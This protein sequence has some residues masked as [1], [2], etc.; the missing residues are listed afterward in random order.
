MQERGRGLTREADITT[1][2]EER[3][4]SGGEQVQRREAPLPGSLFGV[5]HQRGTQTLPLPG[6]RNRQRAEQGNCPVDFQPHHADQVRAIVAP[7]EVSERRGGEIG[8]GQAGGGQQGADGGWI[9]ADVD[10]RECN[11]HRAGP[12]QCRRGPAVAG[13][14]S[15][16]SI[17]AAT[18]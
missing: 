12:V 7:P 13:A 3:L 14:F 16:L 15:M 11:S 9:G 8:S 18:A 4:G 5:G 17:S 1:P 6:G 10:R 2:G